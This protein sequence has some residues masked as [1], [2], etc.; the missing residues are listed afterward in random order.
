MDSVCLFRSFFLLALCSF[1]HKS[2]VQVL[3]LRTCWHP[4]FLKDIFTEY[5]IL[6][7]QFFPCSLRDT[8]CHLLFLCVFSE[9][10]SSVFL[11]MVTCFCLFV[12]FFWLLSRFFSSLIFRSSIMMCLGLG[13]F[14]E[15]GRLSQLLGFVGFCLLSNLGHFQPFHLPVSFYPPPLFHQ[16]PSLFTGMLALFLLPRRCL[17]LCFVFGLRLRMFRLDHFS[18]AVF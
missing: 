1:L 16:L 14:V 13:S 8:L 3:Y 7:W 10:W 6:G 9:E 11:I 5:K 18:C 15:L 12:C 17:G 2:V 4:S